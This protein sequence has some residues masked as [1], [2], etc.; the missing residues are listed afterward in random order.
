MDATAADRPADLLEIGHIR[1]PHGLRGD[2]FVQL[3]SDRDDRLRPGSILYTERRS[4][5][6]AASR[7]AANGRWVVTFEGIGDRAAAEAYTNR[8][9]SAPPIDDPDALWVHELIGSR[10]VDQDGVDRGECVSVVANPASDLL[11]LASGALVPSTFVVSRKGAV[12][13]VDVPDGLFE[14]FE[15]E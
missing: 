4:L 14:L 7:R 10:V 8:S 5:T 1:R 15:G 6:V 11:E 13:N 12:I 3:V 2:V 9:L